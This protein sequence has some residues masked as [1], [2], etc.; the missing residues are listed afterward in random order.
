MRSLVVLLALSG[1]LSGIAA[2]ESFAKRMNEANTL[3]QSGDVDAALDLYHDLEVERPGSASLLYNLGCAYTAQAEKLLKAGQSAPADEAFMRGREVF[4]AAAELSGD[5]LES[6]ASFNRTNSFGYEANLRAGRPVEKPEDR[7]DL[8]KALGKAVDEYLAYVDAN[9]SDARAQHNLAVTSKALQELLSEPPPP[10]SEDPQEGENEEGDQEDQGQQSGKGEENQGQ[11]GEESKP[12]YD[13]SG[14]GNQQQE[15]SDSSSKP[16]EEGGQNSQEQGN[17][18]QGDDEEGE[19]QS[20][21]QEFRDFEEEMARQQ[22][23]EAQ[24][25]EDNG[26]G[27]SAAAQI[28]QSDIPPLTENKQSIR[29][30]LQSLED[31]DKQMQKSERSGGPPARVPPQD[32]W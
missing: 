15:Q 29:A 19:G 23:E 1:M 11:D 28:A 18:E 21:E 7:R 25:G 12:G 4:K 2:A 14:G 3:L 8:E 16:N 6:N 10:P 30:I 27:D 13:Q 20:Q 24:A 31:L 26:E 32:W 22:M 5:E 9:P 17:G